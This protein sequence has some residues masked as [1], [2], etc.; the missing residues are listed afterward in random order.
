MAV[1]ESLKMKK[2]F[3][4]FFLHLLTVLCFTQH[5]T[6]Q[7]ATVYQDPYATFADAAFPTDLLGY[8]A[9]H[10]SGGACILR[11]TDG[12]QTWTKRYIAGWSF[13]DKIA[14]VNDSA[15]YAI[16]GGAPV[17]IIRTTDGFQTYVM[18]NLD[19]SFVV[20]SLQLLTDSTGLYLNN[21][22]RLRRFKDHG[23]SYV[24]L[25]DTLFAGQNLQLVTPQAGYWDTGTGLLK[26][27]N[28][29]LTWAMANPNLGF[30]NVVFRFSDPLRGYFSDAVNVYRT[31]NGGGSFALLDSFPN[32]YDIATQGNTICMA[33]ND[34]GKV[35]ITIDGGLT[36]QHENTGINWIAPERYRCIIT[37]G[38]E[39]YLYCGYCGEIRKRQDRISAVAPA[40]QNAFFAYPNPF[41]E[42]CTLDFEGVVESV[43]IRWVDLLGHEVRSMNFSGQSFHMERGD[44]PAGLYIVYL[45]SQGE[46]IG[47]LKMVAR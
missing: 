15:G 7:W 16:K 14:M 33:A 42:A 2:R 47:Q 3:L 40:A 30:N 27:V 46:M 9:G 12:A 5:A 28:G 25:A 18:H 8:V 6:A 45:S 38:G 43:D 39:S 10:D 35:A 22:G 31:I 41:G 11:T 44:L 21:G 1:I 17:Q 36:W 24:Y 13:M 34:S 4:P 37:P 23:A 19:S 32:V 29:G 20:E 26:T